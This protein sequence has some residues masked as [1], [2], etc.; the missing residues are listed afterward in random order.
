[1]NTTIQKEFD[2]D[3]P[4]GLVWKALAD[5][6]YIV[7]CVPGASLTEKVD[8]RNFKGE[9]V[10]KFGPIK[11]TYTG[12]IEIQ[13]LDETN[14]VMVLKGKGLDSKG[15]GSAD[16]IMNGTLTETDGKTHVK[17]SMN[18]AIV[19]MLAQFGSRLINDVSDQL[20]NQFVENFKAKLAG[21]SVDTDLSAGSMLGAMAKSI[22]G[23]KN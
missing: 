10:A 4:I 11:A 16:M 1:M 6:E 20:L 13:E 17:F 7:T 8:D 15:K 19:G 14:H 23:K 2:I 12:D 22:F 18:I 3:Q 9:V 5:P 21:E